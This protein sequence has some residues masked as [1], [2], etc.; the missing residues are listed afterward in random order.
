MG[1]TGGIML[2][3]ALFF[4]CVATTATEE[5]IGG[6]EN[7]IEWRG[8]TTREQE[9][10]VVKRFTDAGVNPLDVHEDFEDAVARFDGDDSGGLD[11]Y[12]KDS[13]DAEGAVKDQLG[14]VVEEEEEEEEPETSGGEPGTRLPDLGDAWMRKDN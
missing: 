13:E 9:E 8:M 12:D 2:T 6:A 1:R 10:H 5:G 4:C 14:A 3:A 7:I 11:V